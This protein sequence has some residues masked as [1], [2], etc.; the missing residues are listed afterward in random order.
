MLDLCH[1]IEFIHFLRFSPFSSNYHS[2]YRSF[3]LSFFL[4]ILHY[5]HFISFDFFDLPFNL[6]IF[7][8]SGTVCRL[9]RTA[10]LQL[11]FRFQGLCKF[12]FLFQLKIARPVEWTIC[13]ERKENILYTCANENGSQWKTTEQQHEEL[14]QNTNKLNE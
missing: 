2:F 7:Q 11:N 14:H 9:M 13:I 10:C 6:A 8:V 4:M 5:L 12:C 3:T 1:P